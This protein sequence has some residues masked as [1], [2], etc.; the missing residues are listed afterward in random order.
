MSASVSSLLALHPN[1]AR[2]LKPRSYL[3]RMWRRFVFFHLENRVTEHAF[4]HARFRILF[5]VAHA[6]REPA[7]LPDRGHSTF[8]LDRDDI[9][10]LRGVKR[11]RRN[12]NF[13][14]PQPLDVHHYPSTRRLCL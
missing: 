9:I 13:S 2:A 12:F 5:D 6:G 7:R 4:S 11:S 8:G 3:T 14:G 10:E 1:P